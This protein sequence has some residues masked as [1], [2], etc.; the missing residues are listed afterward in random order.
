MSLGSL[1]GEARRARGVTLEQ[2]AAATRIRL[3]H[4]TAL[5]EGRLTELPAPVY[6]RGYLR[7]VYDK[8]G[9]L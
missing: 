5:E 9:V 3:R 4:L 7:T 8:Y 1:L 2:V 6:V